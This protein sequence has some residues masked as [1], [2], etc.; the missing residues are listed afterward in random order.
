MSFR[1]VSELD[2]AVLKKFSILMNPRMVVGS[3]WMSM[4][5]AFGLTYQE[6]LNYDRQ[7]DPTL[8]VLKDWWAEDGDRTVT[9]LIKILE[10]IKRF[11]AV[12]LLRPHEFC[13]KYK[14][15]KCNLKKGTGG[16]PDPK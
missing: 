4:A 10:S 2:H 1:N 12:K 5:G 3:D 8:A 6:I 16:K 14:L 9:A 11:D 13:C 7:I 15:R